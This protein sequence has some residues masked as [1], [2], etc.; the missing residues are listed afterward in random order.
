MQSFSS[1]LLSF[2]HSSKAI[3][4][5][6][7]AVISV[8]VQMTAIAVTFG[9]TPALSAARPGA[10]VTTATELVQSVTAAASADQDPS[11]RVVVPS[12]A[13]QCPDS[14]TGAS[15]VVGKTLVPELG[16]PS[17]PDGL[18]ACPAD[19]AKPMLSTPGACAA[20]AAVAPAPGARPNAN[21]LHQ[22][23]ADAQLALSADRTVLAPGDKTQLVATSDIAVTGTPWAIEIFDQTTQVLVGACS[24]ADA[25]LVAFSA[26]AGA[27]MFIA[28][29]AVPSTTMPV[30]GARLTSAPL[31]VDWLGVT[32]Q[33]SAPS[34][35][36]PGKAVTFTATASGE[37]SNLGYV[38]GLTDST[39]GELLTYCTRG[40]VCSTSLVEAKSGLHQVI[41]ELTPTGASQGAPNLKPAS[42][43]AP[44]IWLSVALAAQIA[45]PIFGGTTTLTATANTDL[46]STPWAISIYTSFGEMVGNPCNAATC[47]VQVTLP[48][49]PPPSFY[50]LIA[51]RAV[52][53]NSSSA[54]GAR[55]SGIVPNVHQDVQAR[56]ETVT[57]TRILWGVD[58]CAAFTQ[59]AAATRGLL[60]S[61]EGHLGEPD[62]WARYLP[63]TGNCPALSAAEIGAAH[64]HHMGILPIYNN[65]DCSAVSGY[66]VAASYADAAIQIARADLIP[67]GVGI[68]IDIEPPGPDCPGAGSVD[69][70]FIRGWSDWISAAG[71]VP[72][73]YGN[74]T[75]G[76]S[77]ALAW[78]ATVTD[79]PAIVTTTYLWSFEPSLTDSF[80]KRTAPQYSPNDA[81][82]AGRYAAWQ[83][84]I[85]AGNTPDVDHDEV[86]S[87]FPLWWP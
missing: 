19:L 35:V 81:G 58:S 24:L 76:S 8:T 46:T 40:T 10:T 56:S 80:A 21:P 47:R 28:Y 20:V 37:V 51:R 30:T 36:G 59:D 75:A 48:A 50:A 39:T 49:G 45:Y 23:R 26:K 60:A 62:F 78:C 86:T 5:V 25:C 71:Y 73:Y 72:V 74:T 79:V 70:A 2:A 67:A 87:R 54:S 22:P 31:K 16:V 27:H 57:P 82:C 55:T 69:P 18:T 1:H 29:L 43:P 84:Q 41:A 64:G 7:L 3:G 52:Q 66:D 42:A 83:Y 32:L 65:Y 9:A 53:G 17:V 12:G 34:I 4:T 33:T 14:G 61:V 77:F 38:I 11:A 15:C 44:A 85:S 6:L 13:R 63:T 68:A